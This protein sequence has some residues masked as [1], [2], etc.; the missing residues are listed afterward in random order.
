[1]V[2]EDGLSSDIIAEGRLSIK[3][4]CSPLFINILF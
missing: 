2:D 1:M 4:K 3:K